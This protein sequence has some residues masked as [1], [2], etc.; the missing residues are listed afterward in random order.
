MASQGSAS[1]EMPSQRDP[2]VIG[3]LFSKPAM[4]DG[5]IF[6][7][8]ICRMNPPTPGHVFALIYKLLVN[9]RN[10][11]QSNIY[12]FLGNEREDAQNPLM[13]HYK[14]YV[15]NKMLGNLRLKDP[16]ISHIKVNFMY[17]SENPNVI[18][19][20]LSSVGKMSKVTDILFVIG[21]D[22]ASMIQIIKKTCPNI[23]VTGIIL[24]RKKADE[25]PNLRDLEQISGTAVRNLVQSNNYA[26]FEEVYAGYLDEPDIRTLW[27][28]LDLVLNQSGDIASRLKT[29]TPAITSFPSMSTMSLPFPTVDQY[30]RKLNN[31]SKGGKRG[32]VRRKIKSN[33]KRKRTIRKQRK[34]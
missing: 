16:S 30:I 6:I 4:P 32:T 3:N 27:N 11:G 24:T 14:E 7:S 17:S 15:I 18:S 10:L 8:T 5:Q 21:Q 33:K 1:I 22:R 23:D 25:P 2:T 19:Y 12:I 9:A 29:H 20:F 26:G 28:S 34:R 31:G 13:N